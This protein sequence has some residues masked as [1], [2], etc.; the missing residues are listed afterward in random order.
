[1]RYASLITVALLGACSLA[2]AEDLVLTGYVQRVILQPSGTE[3]CPPPCPPVTT[4]PDGKQRLCFSNGGGCQ[5][6]EVKVD[7]VYRGAAGGPIRQFKSRIGEW[8][9]TFPVTDKQIV[10]S[11]SGG[12]VFW[13]LAT[14]RDGKIFVDPRRLRT[15]GGVP[16]QPVA[17]GELVALD[18]VLAASAS[19]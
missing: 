4:L 17:D 11:E 5:A 1:M 18:D 2:S 19:R 13:S 7:K 10:V 6:M 9:P 15:H 8:G 3:N 14:V 16:T 12:N